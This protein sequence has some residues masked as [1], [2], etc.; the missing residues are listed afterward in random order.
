[1]YAMVASERQ[2]KIGQWRQHLVREAALS[3]VVADS[4]LLPAL[5]LARQAHL[6]P[7]GT[8]DVA[9]LLHGDPANVRTVAEAA[10]PVHVGDHQA[11]PL[12]LVHG[13]AGQPPAGVG[14]C[15]DE[16]G[17]QVG[18]G[19][20]LAGDGLEVAE[21]RVAGEGG[22]RGGAGAGVPGGRAQAE[23]GLQALEDG[24]ALGRGVGRLPLQGEAD[25]G[26]GAG[27]AEGGGDGDGQQCRVARVALAVGQVLG[28]ADGE[29]AEADRA[30]RAGRA[31]RGAVGEDGGDRTKGGQRE[32]AA[33][34]HGRLGRAGDA[35]RSRRSAG[36]VGRVLVR[37]AGK[38]V[39]LVVRGH[40]RP[41]DDGRGCSPG[42]Q[43]ES[44]RPKLHLEQSHRRAEEV[45]EKEIQPEKGGGCGR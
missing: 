9:P 42:R 23:G 8:R 26:A 44:R 10:D 1:M 29:A 22:G 4:R 15:L 40:Q 18:R 11:K 39:D 34:E 45:K 32:D 38:E 17:R 33:C 20:F 24:Q 7:V 36:G 27:V 30:G 16:A 19:R 25:V 37:V 6:F 3:Q 41:I 13:A 43:E 12:G 35:A 5:L 28:Q 14:V 21:Q 31:G 2:C